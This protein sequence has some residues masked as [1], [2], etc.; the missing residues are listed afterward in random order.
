MEWLEEQRVGQNLGC[1]Q[2]LAWQTARRSRTGTAT[3]SL[4]PSSAANAAT[5]TG[6]GSPLQSRRAHLP[7]AREGTSA[8]EPQRAP[9][10]RLC[11]I[12]LPVHR[13]EYR[14]HA[15]RVGRHSRPPSWGLS[16]RPRRPTCPRGTRLANT[17]VEAAPGRPGRVQA[18]RAQGKAPFDGPARPHPAHGRRSARSVPLGWVKLA[19]DGDRTRPGPGQARRHVLERFAADAVV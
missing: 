13:P 9:L 6:W 14:A 8:H 7:G 19:V 1:P 16:C 3:A 18:D 5:C 11:K 2:T 10:G 17:D 15:A 4:H 12:V